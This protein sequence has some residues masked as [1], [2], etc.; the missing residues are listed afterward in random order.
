M[1]GEDFEHRIIKLDSE[2]SEVVNLITVIVLLIKTA[3]LKIKQ[4][5]IKS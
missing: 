5:V 3:S 2:S 4:P 1:I